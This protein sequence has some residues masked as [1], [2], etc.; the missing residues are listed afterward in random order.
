MSDV[1]AQETARVGDGSGDTSVHPVCRR[2]RR[3]SDVTETSA[4]ASSSEEPPA[5][6]QDHRRRRVRGPQ[7][8]LLTTL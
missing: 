2:R 5:Q 1:Y 6:S 3:H 7:I 4:G 8:S